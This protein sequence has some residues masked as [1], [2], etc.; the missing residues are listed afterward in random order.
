[1]CWISITKLLLV[2]RRACDRRYMRTSAV[3][4][5]L[6]PRPMPRFRWVTG[7]CRVS[8]AQLRQGCS[9]SPLLKTTSSWFGLSPKRRGTPDPILPIYRRSLLATSAVPGDRSSG[10]ESAL[11]HTLPILPIYS[12][13]LLATSAVHG[14]RSSSSES[15]LS[16]TLPISPLSRL[17]LLAASAVPGVRSSGSES[18][19]SHTL[20]ISPL[21]RLRLSLLFLASAQAVVSQRWVTV[22]CKTHPAHSVIS[23]G[24]TDNPRSS[25]EA[26]SDFVFKINL[27]ANE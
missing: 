12:P 18:A 4:R 22:L 14:D 23:H 16:H 19:L 15:A 26:G 1:M 13:S 25:V 5:T 17:S 6:Q 3:A 10:S 7:S 21:S 27:N 20:P 9:P 8:R 11:S 2:C 24:G